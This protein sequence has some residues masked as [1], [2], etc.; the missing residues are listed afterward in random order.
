MPSNI[1]KYLL[2]KIGQ[3]LNNSPGQKSSS[4]K[5]FK[6]TLERSGIAEPDVNVLSNM[7]MLKPHFYDHKPTSCT[8]GCGGKNKCEKNNPNAVAKYISRKKAIVNETRTN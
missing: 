8:C 3:G 1:Q 4:T 5:Q 6:K 2:K 7:P